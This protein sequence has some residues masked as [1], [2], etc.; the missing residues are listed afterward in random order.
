MRI[1]A[2]EAVDRYEKHNGL[3]SYLPTNPSKTLQD[4][5]DSVSLT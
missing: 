4:E 1:T 5:F 3:L 2:T